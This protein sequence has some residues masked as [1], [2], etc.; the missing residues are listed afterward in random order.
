MSVHLC[1]ILHLM[2]VQI[3]RNPIQNAGCYGILQAVR[4]NPDSAVEALDFWVTCK[5]IRSTRLSAT[6]L[7]FQRIQPLP[8]LR[9]LPGHHSQPG[10]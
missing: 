8:C 1:G 5:F 4:E 3:G 6:D 9:S 2:L 10:F 7:L